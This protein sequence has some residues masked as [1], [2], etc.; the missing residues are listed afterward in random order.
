[1][2][3]SRRAGASAT[4]AIMLLV[5]MCMPPAACAWQQH[6]S[7]VLNIHESLRS[8]QS[9]QQQPVPFAAPSSRRRCA[10]LVATA[11]EDSDAGRASVLDEPAT[12]G[13]ELQVDPDG[14]G[15]GVLAL[16]GAAAL[17]PLLAVGVAAT[18]GMG[19]GSVDNDGLGVPLTSAEV[20]DLA[21]RQAA[22]ERA[23][24]AGEPQGGALREEG[25][26][27]SLEEAAEEQALVDVLRGGVRRAR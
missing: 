24:A 10:S 23:A 17:V 7:S 12:A 1:M 3:A 19:V 6:S 14:R 2:G 25:T 13:R 15:T 18:L 8:I 21:R 11:T 4:H 16:A 22:A 9:L 20:R 27:S 26:V 5:C